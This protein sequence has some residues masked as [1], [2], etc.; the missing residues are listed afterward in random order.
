MRLWLFALCLLLCIP[1]FSSAHGQTVSPTAFQEKAQGAVSGG[2]SI[3]S[4]MLSA[5]A[6]WVAGSQSESGTAELQANADGSTNV[7]LNLGSA[8][9]TETRTKMDGSRTCQWTDS[10]GTNH[11]VLGPNCLIAIPWFAAS[12]FTQ[13]ASRVS[14]LIVTT[15][16]GA[17]SKDGATFHQ[18]SYL[19]NLQGA[20]TNSTNQS[21]S[22]SRVKV[23]YDPQTFLPASLEYF[24]HPDDNNLQNIPVRVVFSSYQSISGVM[25][26]FHIDKY[27][28][29]TL[30]LSLN[31]NNASIQ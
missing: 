27:V 24:I 10:A 12:L 26:P 17:I 31:V 30:Q 2:K 29:R 15:D 16:D 20:D 4:I 28:Q 13:P 14:P 11:E 22:W 21:I 7:Q 23:L 9:R 25:L 8:S 6:V 18:I 1:V 3:Q 5:S 19:L